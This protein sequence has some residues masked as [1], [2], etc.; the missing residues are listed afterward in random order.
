V[1]GARAGPGQVDDRDVGAR[2]D[3]TGAQLIDD[4]AGTAS[5][6]GG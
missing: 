6:R 1:I 3:R 5:A 2:D 4:L